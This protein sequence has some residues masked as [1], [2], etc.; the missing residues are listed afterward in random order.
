MPINLVKS[1]SLLILAKIHSTNIIHNINTLKIT[2]EY[3]DI[4][5]ILHFFFRVYIIDKNLED[6]DF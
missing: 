4:Y 1:H 6:I 3:F 2:L 5:L